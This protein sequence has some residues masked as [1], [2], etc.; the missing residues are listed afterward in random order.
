MKEKKLSTQQPSE[1]T[2]MK[3]AE[4]FLNTSVPRILADLEKQQEQVKKSS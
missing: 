1:E 4:F 3:M 2:K